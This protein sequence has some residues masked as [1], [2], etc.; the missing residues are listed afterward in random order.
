MKVMDGCNA[1]ANMAYNLSEISFIYP[2][3]P[4]SPMASQIDLL[5][6]EGEKNVF[7]ETV[8]CIEMQSEAGA[9]GA[10]HGALSAGTLASTFTSSQGLLLMLPN[11]YKIAGEMLPG[12]IHV[13]ARSL[14]SHALSIFG[15]HQDIYAARTTGFAMLASTN[16]QDAHNLALIAHLSAIEGSIPFLHF[17]DGFRTSHEYNMVNEISKEKILPLINKNKIKEFRNKA[18]NSGRA[19]TRGTAQNEDI[20]FQVAEGKNKIYNEIP[21]IVARQMNKLNK[22]IN[23]DYAPFNYYGS[24]EAKYVIV[25]MGS[26]CDTIKEVVQ[27]LNKTD[28]VHGLIEVHLY[29]PFS[30][31]YLEKVLPSTVKKIAVLDRTKEQGSAGEPLYLDVLASLSDKKCE[32]YGGRYGLSSKNTTPGDIYDVFMML[33]K[34]TKNNFTIGIADDVTFTDLLKHGYTTKNKYTE[35]KIYGFGSDGLVSASKDILKIIGKTNSVQGYFEY[36]S[37]KSGGVTISHLR[38]ANKLIEA[39]YYVTSPELVVVSK[40]EYFHRFDMISNIKE[41][42]SLLINTAKDSKK[43]NEFL[44]TKVKKIISERKINVYIIDAESIAK[45]NNISGKI[46]LIIEA[47]ILQLLGYSNYEKILV[48]A[49]KKRFKEKGD[50]IVTANIKSLNASKKEL[51]KID[52]NENETYDIKSKTDVFS[53]INSREGGEL[54]VKDLLPYND[55]TFP[56]GTTANEKRKMSGLVPKWNKEACIEC[57]ICSIVCPHAVVRPF[58]LNKGNKYSDECK[59]SIEKDKDFLI[60]ISEADCTGCGLCVKECPKKSFTIDTHDGKKQKIADDLFKNH[61]NP[62]YPL[63]TIRGTQFKK[64]LFEFSGACAGCGETPYIKLLTQLFGEKL[65]IANATGCS[66]IYGGSC[67]SMP[68]NISWANSLFEDNAEFGLG[69]LESY[70]N[71]KIRI[72]NILKNQKGK[73]VQKFYSTWKE[74]NTD[75]NKAV[76]LKNEAIKFLPEDLIDYITPKSV[77]TVGGDGWAYDIGFGGLDHVLSSGENVNILILDTEVYSNTGGQASKSSHVGAVAEFAN[78]GKKTH[79]KDLFKI[80]MN[81][82]DIYVAS[83]SLGANMMHAIKVFT[84]AEKHQGPSIIIAYSPCVEH[85]IK[86]G[87][88]NSV[89][90]QKLAVESGYMLLMRYMDKKLYVDSA[91]PNFDKYQDFLHNEVRYK[92]LT[93]K[94]KKLADDLLALNKKS[95]MDRYKFYKEMSTK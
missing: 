75:Y 25:A 29:R 39:P 38:I 79:K 7:N 42:G 57:G 31:K 84:E 70:N 35:F 73:K 4:S 21:D 47:N 13:A 82:P 76:E 6:N 32:I 69:I 58:I 30:K 90:E 94:D 95:A 93:I 80:A 15:D 92:S 2:I 26:A 44:P 10:L 34:N 3:T 65:V 28:N 51:K 74:C 24:K 27:D 83:I 19:I 52:I 66:S 71:Q 16:V 17:F 88:T 77:W 81:Y 18:L 5:G 12:V 36:D 87:L 50:D 41:K 46:S 22:T 33:K 49:I 64:P 45:A 8:K 86:G 63:T 11:M 53:K 72:D 59:N 68:Y 20:Y 55:G 9:A 89:S 78:M 37:K 14:A 91:E 85:G 67:P 56:G 40:E 60:S 61:V 1:C 62:E 54:T 43:L 48:E 23:T